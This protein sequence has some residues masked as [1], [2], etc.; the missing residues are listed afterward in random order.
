MVTFD[1]FSSSLSQIFG[2]FSSRVLTFLKSF[3][4]VHLT[5]PPESDHLHI[6][7]WLRCLRLSLQTCW[8]KISAHIDEAKVTG[9]SGVLTRGA[10]TSISTSINFLQK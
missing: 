7:V 4:V 6:G 2:D 1:V 8:Q 10:M 9:F 5:Y 3:S